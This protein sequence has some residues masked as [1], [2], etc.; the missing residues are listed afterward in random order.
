MQSQLDDTIVA[1]ATA[2]GAAGLAVVRLS[3]PRAVEIGAR[4]FRGADLVCSE[5]HRAH[6]GFAVDIA[7]ERIDKVL[8]LVLRGPRSYTGE[9]TVEFSCHGSP[10]VVDELV[11]AALAAGARLAGPGEFTRRAFLNGRIDLWQVEAGSDLIAAT[12]RAARRAAL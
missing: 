1:P 9:D 3:G 12:S 5:S 6:H 7:G 11:Q 10:Q 4:L 2:A 8:V